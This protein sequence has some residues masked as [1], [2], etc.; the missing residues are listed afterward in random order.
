MMSYS[1]PAL[2]VQAPWATLLVEGLKS[3]ETRS[4]PIPATYVGKEILLIETPG[5]NKK[6]QSRIVGL[7]VFGNSFQYR[8]LKQ[9]RGD[10]SKHL[11]EE[12]SKF[13]WHPAKSK[14]GWP[15]LRYSK[16][17]HPLPKGFRGGIIYSKAVAIPK[18]ELEKS[19]KS[20]RQFA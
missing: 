2:N 15:V 9:F 13:C 17:A 20:A 7:I 14:W 18:A 3:I 12:A 4:Y 6:L 1:L 19:R 10:V 11:V 16:L 8:S 5:T